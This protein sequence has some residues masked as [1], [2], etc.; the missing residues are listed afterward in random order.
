M[1]A[2]GIVPASIPR[3]PTYESSCITIIRKALSLLIQLQSFIFFPSSFSR[4]WN[5]CGTHVLG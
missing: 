2:R 3:G 1:A 4:I 5:S